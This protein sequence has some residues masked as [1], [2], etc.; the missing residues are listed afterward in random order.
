[1]TIDLEFPRHFATYRLTTFEIGRLFL[2]RN[3]DQTSAW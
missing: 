2:R 1:M 3:S